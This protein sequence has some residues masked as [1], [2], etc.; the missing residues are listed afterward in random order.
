MKVNETLLDKKSEWMTPDL[1]TKIA[2]NPKLPKLFT[3]PEYLQVK[4][5]FLSNDNDFYTYC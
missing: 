1:L 2:A 5:N 3:N 4:E